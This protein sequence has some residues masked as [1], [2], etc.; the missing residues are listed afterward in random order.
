MPIPQSMCV[1]RSEANFRYWSVP[2]TMFERVSLDVHCCIY[3]AGCPKFGDSLISAFQLQ[4]VH[5]DYN[6][7][8]VLPDFGVVS[9]DPDSG[10]QAWILRTIM[11][12]PVPCPSVSVFK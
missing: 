3:C 4:V 6:C 12:N 8:A 11:S 5:R 1:S 9:K 7:I 2:S 10:L